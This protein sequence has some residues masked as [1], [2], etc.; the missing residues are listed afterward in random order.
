VEGDTD[1]KTG[2]GSTK[3]PIDERVEAAYASYQANP[4][5]RRAWSDNPGNRAAHTE[6]KRALMSIAATQLSGEGPILDVGCGTGAWVRVLSSL[7]DQN[8]LYALDAVASRLQAA[9]AAASGG[10]FFHA[11]ARALPFTSEMFDLVLLFTVLTDLPDT[12]DI[13]RVL[14]ECDRVL[15]PGGVLM[16]YEPRT[17]NPLNPSTRAIRSRDIRLPAKSRTL[18]LLPPLARRLGRL[19]PLLYQPLATVPILRTHRLWWYD[20]AP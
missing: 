5:K 18:T 16:I 11:N 13:E 4:R 15:A 3:A 8:R 7:V 20:K 6:L 1:V 10:H 2:D 17:P 19:T 9:R 14:S 12:H